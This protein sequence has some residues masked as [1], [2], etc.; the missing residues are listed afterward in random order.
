MHS[1]RM[2]VFNIIN[3]N[4]AKGLDRNCSHHKQENDNDVT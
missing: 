3:F 1:R 4:I 2:I